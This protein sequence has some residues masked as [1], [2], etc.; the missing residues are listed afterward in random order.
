MYESDLGQRAVDHM[1]P[2][3]SLVFALATFGLP[4]FGARG[5]DA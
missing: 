2:G 4:G 3:L 5:K 1:K